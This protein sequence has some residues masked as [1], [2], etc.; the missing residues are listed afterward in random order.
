MNTDK[1]SNKELLTDFNK[2]LLREGVGTHRRNKLRMQF[3]T[4]ER[5]FNHK[6]FFDITREDIEDFVDRLH[7]NTFA[8]LDGTAFSGISK[9]DIKKD[10]K[11]IWKWYKGDNERRLYKSKSEV[12]RS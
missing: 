5:G 9:Q 12:R 6:P 7:N 2:H 3:R 4:I 10:I 1:R 8:K 11:Q